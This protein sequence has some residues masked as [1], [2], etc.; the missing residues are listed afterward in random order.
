M[1]ELQQHFPDTYPEG[2]TEL[3]LCLHLSRKYPVQKRQRIRWKKFN[4][5][6]ALK[7]TASIIEDECCRDDQM[8]YIV[9]LFNVQ[10]LKYCLRV[11]LHSVV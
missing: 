5:K 10:G 1:Y 6:S 2:Y 8:S 9:S 11:V 4:R 3:N 7:H